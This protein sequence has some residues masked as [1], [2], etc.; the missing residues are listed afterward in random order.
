MLH[1]NQGTGS[2]FLCF[3][4]VVILWVE[5]VKCALQLSYTFSQKLR[6]AGM[7]WELPQYYTR[8]SATWWL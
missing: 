6:V 2:V 1:N 8:K 7:G 5:P 4:F 3:Y